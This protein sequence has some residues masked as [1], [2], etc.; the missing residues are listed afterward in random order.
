MC[1][2]HVITYGQGSTKLKGKGGSL[3][4][5]E[6]KFM[7]AVVYWALTTGVKNQLFLTQICGSAW[8]SVLKRPG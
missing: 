6:N 1:L 2:L 5:I 7:G 4:D 3:G 8:L